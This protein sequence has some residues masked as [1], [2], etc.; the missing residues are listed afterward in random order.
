MTCGIQYHPMSS[1][2]SSDVVIDTVPCLTYR[3]HLVFVQS[4]FCPRPVI[5]SYRILDDTAT[6]S[7]TCDTG[8]DDTLPI[9]SLIALLLPAPLPAEPCRPTGRLKARRH[10]TRYSSACSSRLVSSAHPFRP[11]LATLRPMRRLV[12]SSISSAH[13]LSRSASRPTS[14]RA[15]IL[16]SPRFPPCVPPDC[17]NRQRPII[18]SHPMRQATSKTE[19]RTKRR[20]Q[21]RGNE[22]PRH[23]TPHGYRQCPS[24]PSV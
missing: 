20:K 7:I 14:R 21:R 8:Y 11:L 6:K 5:I 10:P 12:I 17:S 9:S 22:T 18:P 2:M 3:H 16:A 4:P 1:M 23:P 15:S 19:R 24:P 13:L